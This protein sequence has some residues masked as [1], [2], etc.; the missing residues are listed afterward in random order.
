MAAVF[1]AAPGHPAQHA[2]LITAAYTGFALKAEA[3]DPD[4]KARMKQE[5][6][7]SG[8]QKPHP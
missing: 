8:V 4:V 5:E 7:V 3:G 6:A 2:V 1:K